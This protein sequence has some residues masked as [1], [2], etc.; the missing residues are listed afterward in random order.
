MSSSQ[1]QMS[2]CKVI[3]FPHKLFHYLNSFTL[4]CTVAKLV[5]RYFVTLFILLS[6]T[7]IKETSKSDHFCDSLAVTVQPS[8]TKHHCHRMYYTEQHL[9]WADILLKCAGAD[10]R[11][12][13]SFFVVYMYVFYEENYPAPLLPDHE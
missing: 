12:F 4:G 3:F 13:P 2:K 5:A 6:F 8:N 1:F 9:P 10:F 11:F 7:L